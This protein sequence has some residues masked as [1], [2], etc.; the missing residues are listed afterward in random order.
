V[1]IKGNE[2][3]TRHDA[4]EDEDRPE[5]RLAPDLEDHWPTFFAAL[6]AEG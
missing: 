1:V 2:G 5:Q 6:M 3:A 4:E